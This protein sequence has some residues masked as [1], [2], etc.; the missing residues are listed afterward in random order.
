MLAVLYGCQQFHQYVFGANRKKL[1]I[2]TDHICANIYE[3]RR[4]MF[5]APS[6]YGYS[7]A[8]VLF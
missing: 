2:G 4:V 1:K 7:I 8:E 6:V 3:E 5:S